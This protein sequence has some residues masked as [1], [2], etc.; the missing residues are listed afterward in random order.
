M[1]QI[2]N[3]AQE[4]KGFFEIEFG[5]SLTQV[6]CFYYPQQNSIHSILL[7]SKSKDKL[8]YF[9]LLMEFNLY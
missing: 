6:L 3:Q 9:L 2:S 8:H 1:D 5:L 4:K 7:A